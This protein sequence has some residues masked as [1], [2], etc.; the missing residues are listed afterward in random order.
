MIVFQKTKKY[1]CLVMCFVL[2]NLLVAC[3][4]NSESKTDETNRTNVNVDLK[5]AVDEFTADCIGEWVNGSKYDDAY[6]HTL[7]INEVTENKVAFKLEYYRL[8]GSDAVTADIQKNCSAIFT[9]SDGNEGYIYLSDNKISVVFT[10]SVT[11]WVNVETLTYERTNDINTESKNEQISGVHSNS[12]NTNTYESSSSENKE[13]K[14]KC[15]LC[16]SKPKSGSQYCNSH[17]CSKSGCPNQKEG[18]RYC[19]EHKC[20]SC[21]NERSR[22]S[23]YCTSHKCSWYSG[24]NNERVKN[25][26]YCTEHKCANSSCIMKKESNSPYCVTHK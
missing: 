4:D 17:A 2:L 20:L 6:E 1:L 22:D 11:E 10:K 14:E 9:T 16:S 25:S 18:T 19:N 26:Q 15:L 7:Y 13:E 21:D 5:V 8:W 24:C 3:K 12:I 23:M